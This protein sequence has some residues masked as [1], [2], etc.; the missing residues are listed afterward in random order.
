VTA[1]R[2]L[3]GCP[4]CGNEPATGERGV[5]FVVRCGADECDGGLV[6]TSHHISAWGRT[7][8]EADARWR[9]LAGAGGEGK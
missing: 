7:Q 8:A 1:P 4:V 5:W 3:P 9:R 6:I 2:T